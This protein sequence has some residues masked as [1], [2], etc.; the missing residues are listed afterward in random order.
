MST[1]ERRERQKQATRNS[2]LGAARQIARAEGWGAVTVRRVAERVEYAPP[3]IYE[4]FASK[5]ALLEELQRLGFE[6]L[7][8]SLRH[9][10]EETG[11]SEARLLQ[12]ADA[13]WSFAQGQPELHQLM[14]DLS[15]VRVPLAK[16][17]SAATLAGDIAQQALE[18]WAESRHVTLPDPA[19][20]VETLWGLLHGL[21][22]AAMLGRLGGGDERARRLAQ[23]GIKNLLFA[24]A[25]A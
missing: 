5:D 25:A 8:D 3:I 6:Q 24:W 7:A 13:Y 23:E 10:S 22:S 16:T 20:A 14:H 15:S 2:I 11:D 17:L 21:T 12:M 19:G 1:T 9:A 18:H 4:Y